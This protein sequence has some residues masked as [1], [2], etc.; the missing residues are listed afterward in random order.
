[1]FTVDQ[2]GLSF[3]DPKTLGVNTQDVAE[4][5]TDAGQFYWGN[6][7]SWISKESILDSE[8]VPLILSRWETIDIDEEEDLKIALA[9]KKNRRVPS[10]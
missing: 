1:M 2:K 9:L 10:K 8:S 7:A 3:T 5:Y 6:F 4:F